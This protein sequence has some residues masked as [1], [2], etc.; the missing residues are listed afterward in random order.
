M[1]SELASFLKRERGYVVLFAAVLVF[2]TAAALLRRD[3][4]EQKPSPKLSQILDAEKALGRSLTD[5]GV[6]QDLAGRQPFLR[7]LLVVLTFTF[8]ASF[9]YGLA[10]DLTFL[11]RT[12]LGARATAGRP[13]PAGEAVAAWWGPGAIF[14]VV[15]LYLST[16]VLLNLLVG[17]GEQWLGA[18][19]EDNWLLLMHTLLTDLAT[20]FLIAYVVGS[21][22][23]GTWDAL[24]L[25]VS[26]PWRQIGA[27]F[28]GYCA[29]LPVFVFLLALIVLVSNLLGYEPP[30]HPLV[31]VFVEEDYRN[32][33][34]IGFSIFLACAIGPV[35]EEIFFRGFCYPALK[36]RWGRLWALALTSAFFSWVHQSTFAFWPV[37][38]LGLAL[39]LLYER[40]RSLL[41][42]IAMHVFHNSLFIGYFF[43]VKR[44]FLDPLVGTP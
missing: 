5:P 21:V 22:G 24:G 6:A 20:I 40:E 8:V 41:P 26:Q 32:P 14:K 43:I 3:A 39:A 16:T 30:P 38:A 7:L 17:V 34:L 11:W 35:V 13:P 1:F 18:V 31:E 12:F 19:S 9:V 4:K 27:G 2:Y 33:V 25:R 29:V 42:P 10:L 36:R 37:F 23:R 15:T 28:A 44:L